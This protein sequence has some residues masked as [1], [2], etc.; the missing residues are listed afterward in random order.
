MA[1]PFSWQI[2][3]I[4][5]RRPTSSQHLPSLM[6]TQPYAPEPQSTYQV[7]CELG[8]ASM[9]HD[10]LLIVPRMPELW[11]EGC[12]HRRWRWGIGVSLMSSMKVLSFLSP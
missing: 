8:H 2:S 7:R 3:T 10:D 1:I 4:A 6:L 5:Q 9:E 12:V 11:Q